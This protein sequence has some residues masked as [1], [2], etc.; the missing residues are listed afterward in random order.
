MLFRSQR[1][2]FFDGDT[3]HILAPG[4]IDRSFTVTSI[5]DEEGNPREGAP[6]PKERLYIGCD[7]PV[8][9]GDILRLR[10]S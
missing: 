10:L 9:E 8:H 4:D 2:R 6:H 5:T 3:L 1:N 7:E